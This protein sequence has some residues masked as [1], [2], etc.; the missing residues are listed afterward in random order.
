MG[1]DVAGTDEL[2]MVFDSSF[3]KDS[4]KILAEEMLLEQKDS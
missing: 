1:E 3:D 2:E 4:H